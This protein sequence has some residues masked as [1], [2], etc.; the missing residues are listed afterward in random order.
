MYMLV[1]IDMGNIRKA[2]KKKYGVELVDDLIQRCG[3][4]GPYLAQIAAKGAVQQTAKAS[5]VNYT[6]LC[7]ISSLC[8]V[9]V[10]RLTPHTL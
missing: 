1:Q 9:D 2:Y 4:I 5:K 7:V 3:E 10:V 8:D 6:V